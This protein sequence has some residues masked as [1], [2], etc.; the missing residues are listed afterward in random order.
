MSDGRSAL[1]IVGCAIVAAGATTG[2]MQFAP[3]PLVKID[4][5]LGAQRAKIIPCSSTEATQFVDS[6]V[7]A[8]RA[9]GRARCDHETKSP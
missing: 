9:Y 3:P 1:R 2:C 5:T 7:L 8:H 4:S 6:T